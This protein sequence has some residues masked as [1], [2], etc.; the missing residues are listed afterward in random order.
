MVYLMT[1]AKAATLV[2]TLQVGESALCPNQTPGLDDEEDNCRVVAIVP[3]AGVVIMVED[4][5]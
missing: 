5:S 3:D 4:R 2:F 1:L